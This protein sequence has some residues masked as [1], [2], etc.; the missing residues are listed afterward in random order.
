M[1]MLPSKEI[2]A[3]HFVEHLAFIKHTLKTRVSINKQL[4]HPEWRVKMFRI[5]QKQTKLKQMK[6]K[7]FEIQKKW[8]VDTFDNQHMMQI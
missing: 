3:R 2:L 8:S 7:A 4:S 5:Y 6:K 1:T